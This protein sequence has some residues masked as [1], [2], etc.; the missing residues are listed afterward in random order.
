MQ[1]FEQIG[2][3]VAPLNRPNV[4]TD[5][6]IP[7]QFLK[8]IRRT[9][10]GVNLFDEWR[11]L[12][13]G[14]PGQDCAQRPRNPAFPLNQPRYAGAQIL[15]AQENFG[16]GSSREHAVWALQEYGFRALIAPSFGDIFYTNCFKNG[17]LPV[18]LSAAAIV[19]LFGQVA[20]SPGYRLVV[21]LRR[22]LV[23]TPAGVE[24]PFNVD[25]GNR[26]RL[27]DGLDEIALTM[28]SADLIRA[29]ETTRRQQEPWL[30]EPSVAEEPRS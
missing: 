5:A 9:G 29:Y 8:S 20:A 14:I 30:F 3:L 15:L 16:C 19:D 7:K 26:R 27:L 13:A 4:D 22:Q 25:Q 10:F 12:D 18:V 1:A 2:A 28:Q 21:D 11:Y 24:L 23:R 6:I 17:V